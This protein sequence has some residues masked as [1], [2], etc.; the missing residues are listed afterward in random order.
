METFLSKMK[1]HGQQSNLAVYV[2]VHRRNVNRWVARKSIPSKYLKRVA[3]YLKIDVA[4]LL[5]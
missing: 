2:G 1:I 5:E 4:S 3:E